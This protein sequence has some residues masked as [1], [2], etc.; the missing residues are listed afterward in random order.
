MAK[1]INGFTKI[2]VIGSIVH[3]FFGVVAKTVN[4][5]T[6]IYIIGSSVHGFFGV[7]VIC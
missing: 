3:G 4:G 2:Y 1:T 5:F 6:K 7:V